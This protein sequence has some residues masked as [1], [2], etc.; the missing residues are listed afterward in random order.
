MI[1][2]HLT[3]LS[4]L[5]RALGWAAISLLLVGSAKGAEPIAHPFSGFAFPSRVASFHREQVT[6]FDKE[7]KDLG[8]G[9]NDLKAPAAITI[10]VYPAAALYSPVSLRKEFNDCRKALLMGHE[11]VQT[12]LEGTTKPRG[13][14]RGFGGI[15]AYRDIFAGEKQQVVSWLTVYQKDSVIVKFRETYPDVTADASAKAIGKFREAFV[16]PK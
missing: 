2:N 13:K 11:G 3:P 1:M 14:Y 4:A 9:Y 8:V 16:W 7:G 5:S 10:Y 15:Y 6:R 12:V